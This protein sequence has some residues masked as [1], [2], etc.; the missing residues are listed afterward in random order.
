MSISQTASMTS[1]YSKDQELLIKL[2]AYNPEGTKAEKLE[3]I[4]EFFQA[5][6]TQTILKFLAKEASNQTAFSLILWL[7][8]NDL[9]ALDWIYDTAYKISTDTTSVPQ[10]AIK[11][12][13]FN[14]SSLTPLQLSE[15]VDQTETL[16]TSIKLDEIDP[17]SLALSLEPELAISLLTWL[18]SF[19]K[20]TLVD[21]NNIAEITRKIVG[22]SPTP[23]AVPARSAPNPA[24]EAPSLRPEGFPPPRDSSLEDLLLALNQRQGGNEEQ[25]LCRTLDYF[26]FMRATDPETG[27]EQIIF[28]PGMQASQY[29]SDGK[30]KRFQ[31]LPISSTN[32]WSP[33]VYLLEKQSTEVKVMRL[34]D[35][36]F[37]ELFPEGPDPYLRALTIQST[38]Y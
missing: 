5:D 31:P 23:T 33:G 4:I 7:I 8:S 13:Y 14:S 3:Q 6:R 37:F 20:V 1:L 10:V 34:P 28:K 2:E 17:K 11:N 36:D 9:V 22:S 25:I 38:T 16:L 15:V 12:L 35:C 21:L 19:R 18:L 30:E 32:T 27:A 26:L 29:I 24:E